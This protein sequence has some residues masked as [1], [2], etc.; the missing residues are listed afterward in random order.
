MG[1]NKNV[2]VS[3]S[4][5]ILLLLSL[6][7][8]LTYNSKCNQSHNT[9]GPMMQNSQ[10]SYNVGNYSKGP[11]PFYIE[12]F[13]EAEPFTQEEQFNNPGGPQ[14]PKGEIAKWKD[15]HEGAQTEICKRW[16]REGW[17][18][19]VTE[20]NS[21]RVKCNDV[22]PVYYSTPAERKKAEDKK[23]ADDA[24]AAAAYKARLNELK[25]KKK[26]RFTDYNEGMNIEEGFN[27]YEEG[28]TVEQMADL[29]SVQM[30]NEVSPQW[31]A[32]ANQQTQNSPMMASQGQGP[33]GSF[34]GNSSF[35]PVSNM[36]GMGGMGGMGAGGGAGAGGS[37]QQG[38]QSCFPRDR[39]SADDLLPKDAADSKWAQINPSGG[40]N[41]GDQNYLTAGYHVGVNTVGQSLRNANLQL[42]S[43]IPNPQDAVGPWMIS[44]IE[45]DLR[46]NT[47]EIGSSISY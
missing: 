2:V 17:D 44:T 8:L 37:N 15:A 32:R 20:L 30:S 38:M 40:G 39:L 35:Q 7:L 18:T 22:D 25:N 21:G 6:L 11:E 24:A 31:S 19:T 45:P 28:M 34:N 3:F 33:A 16:K 46:Q 23:V 42:R 43:E 36:G 27:N 9:A 13:S 29:A 10:N 26:S 5:A 1:T 41:I 47:L 12:K 4:I 14:V